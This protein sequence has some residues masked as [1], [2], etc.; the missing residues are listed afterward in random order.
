MKNFW[1]SNSTLIGGHLSKWDDPIWRIKL[2]VIWSWNGT[3][4]T[5]IKVQKE[6]AKLLHVIFSCVFIQVD[7]DEIR[8]EQ[9]RYIGYHTLAVVSVV[10]DSRLI[11]TIT[12]WTYKLVY[13][14]L[15]FSVVYIIVVYWWTNEW[16]SGQSMEGW[17]S[18]YSHYTG[19]SCQTFWNRERNRHQSM[20]MAKCVYTSD[21]NWTWDL[22]RI[23]FHLPSVRVTLTDGRWKSILYKSH[24]QPLEYDY[25]VLI[26]DC[27]SSAESTQIIVI[28]VQRFVV[29][30][31]L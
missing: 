1:E 16:V 13:C 2:T 19:T 8:I 20:W 10:S 26:S 24:V 11:I 9:K 23:D 12:G 5:F 3:L 17:V 14:L 21:F 29:F 18:I 15:K 31:D 22:Q 30:E 6:C 25:N 28:N 27:S 4:Y 7:V